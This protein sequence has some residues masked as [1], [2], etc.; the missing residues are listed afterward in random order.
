H[1]APN[2]GAQPKAPFAAVR[3]SL[4]TSSVVSSWC[5][6]PPQ[7]TF[8]SA[9]NFDGLGGGHEQKFH[10]VPR[11]QLPYATNISSYHIGN[12]RVSASGL[13]VDEKDDRLPI[14]R[15]LHCSKRYTLGQ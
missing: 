4:D 1:Q 12:L 6:R 9:K 10:L 2:P 8:L 7:Q 3:R 5:K 13:L 15:Y 11:T 14:G